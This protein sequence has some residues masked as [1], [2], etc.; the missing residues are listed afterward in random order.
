MKRLSATI[1]VLLLLFACGCKAEVMHSAVDF[2]C[3]TVVT[4]NAYAPQETVDDAIRLMRDYERVLS[5]TVEGSDVW[6]LNHANGQPTEVNP[7]T[8]ELLRLSV[9]IASRSGGAFDVTVAPLSALWDFNAETPVLPDPDA[10]ADAAKRVDYRNIAID[11]NTVTLKNGAEIDLGGVAKGYIA[12]RV[13]A[14]LRE[15]GVRS[16]CINMGGNILVFGGKPNGAK[17]SIGVRDPNGTAADSEEVLSL[18]DGA[19]VTSGSYERGFDLDGVRY[20]HIL[21]PKTGMP[22]QNGLASVTILCENSATADALSTACFVLGPTASG[23]LL[24]AYGANAIFL[25]SDG[26]RIAVP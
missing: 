9:E 21:D 13:A 12:D 15:R 17:W 10:L 23:E 19:V 4:V 2:V 6:K 20:H 26:T 5:K 25:C 24:A 16:A 14:F 3:D 1:L 22:V 7:E 8:A 18:S 11:G